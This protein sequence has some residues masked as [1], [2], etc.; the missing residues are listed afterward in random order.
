[1]SLSIFEDDVDPVDEFITEHIEIMVST[2]TFLRIIHILILLLVIFYGLC[3]VM[4]I[5]ANRP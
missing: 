5:S 1:M 4:H 2:C 3:R